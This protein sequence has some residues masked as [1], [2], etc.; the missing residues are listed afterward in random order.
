[1]RSASTL[2]SILIPSLLWIISMRAIIIP[3]KVSYAWNPV[4]LGNPSQQNLKDPQSLD[5]YSYSDDNPIIKQDPTGRTSAIIPGQGFV[6][7]YNGTNETVCCS[8][9]SAPS[10]SGNTNRTSVIPPPGTANEVLPTMF[11]L[12]NFGAS[13]TSAKPVY[14]TPLD[15]PSLFSLFGSVT[16]PVNSNLSSLPIGLQIPKLQQL[17]SQ[18]GLSVDE[19]LKRGAQSASGAID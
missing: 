1:M 4:F 10:G 6:Y 15:T 2:G 12:L 11:P 3:H 8:S 14:T 16:S 18:T 17:S 19:I 7:D 13:W 9:Q 5:A